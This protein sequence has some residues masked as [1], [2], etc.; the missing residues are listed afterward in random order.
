MSTFNAR[1]SKSHHYYY[2]KYSITIKNMTYVW[3]YPKKHLHPQ[4]NESI[5]ATKEGKTCDKKCL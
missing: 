1:N 4:T 5:F 2:N 3:I